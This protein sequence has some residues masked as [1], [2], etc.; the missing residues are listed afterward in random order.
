MMP[1]INAQINPTE[2]KWAEKEKFG[3]YFCVL[4]NCYSQSL[5]C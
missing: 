4:F 3:N 1:H 5:S 2:F